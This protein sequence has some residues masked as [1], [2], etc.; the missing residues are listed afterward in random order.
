MRVIGFAGWSGAGK[1]T[2]IVKLIENL[3]A[4]NLSVSTLKHAHHA[5]N[6]DQPGKDSFVHRQAGAS[7]VLIA[8]AN[9]WALLH[10]INGAA[11]PRLEAHLRRLSPVDLVLIEGFK[12]EAHCKIEV[13][14]MANGKP[15]LYKEDPTIIAVASDARCDFPENLPRV[16]LNDIAGVADLVLRFAPPLEQTLARLALP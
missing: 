4:R 7:E 2:L 5:F 3:R 10:E 11:E 9:R 16:D 14:R 1:T 12:R 8:S 13:H 15:W 6:L